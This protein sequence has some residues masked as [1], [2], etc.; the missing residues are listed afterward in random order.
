MDIEIHIE[1][2]VLEGF[3]HGYTQMTGILLP[4]RSALS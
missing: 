1:E 3:P 4:S 2:L